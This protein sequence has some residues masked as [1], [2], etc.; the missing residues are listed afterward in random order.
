MARK[1]AAEQ[2][3]EQRAEYRRQRDEEER[4]RRVMVIA[5]FDAGD[6]EGCK[7]LAKA[8]GWADA[9][10]STL[11][12]VYVLMGL[13]CGSAAAYAFLRLRL[14]LSKDAS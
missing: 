1:R 12:R 10:E 9:G 6:P 8:I 4:R 13:L 14:R 2:R 5:E 3:A 7:L 11:V